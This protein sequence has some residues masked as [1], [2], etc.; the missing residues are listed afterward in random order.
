MKAIRKPQK[1]D[2]G[3]TTRQHEYVHVNGQVKAF[4]RR[5][6][7]EQ[8]RREH[9]QESLKNRSPPATQKL[10]K[11]QRRGQSKNTSTKLGS[12]EQ[13]ARLKNYLQWQA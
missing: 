2:E 12:K 1:S 3:L 5:R 9:C 11:K 4:E 8:R 13:I 10:S 6:K 7:A